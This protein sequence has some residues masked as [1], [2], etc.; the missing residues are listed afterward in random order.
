MLNLLTEGVAQSVVTAAELAPILES[1]QAQ[2][3]VGNIIGVIAIVV[4]AG[5]GFVFAWWGVRF[6]TRKVVKA[7]TKGKL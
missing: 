7:A 4:G 6:V 1:L 2:L 5:V 3:T